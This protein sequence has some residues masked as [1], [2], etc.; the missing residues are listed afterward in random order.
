MRLRHARH[1]HLKIDGIF[2]I[3][4][5]KT[6]ELDQ[7]DEKSMEQEHTDRDDRLVEF[8]GRSQKVR[9]PSLSLRAR[10][11]VCQDMLPGKTT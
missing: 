1:E 5:K 3:D 10:Q 11:P 8:T 9:D 6:E 4:Q 7:P 2:E